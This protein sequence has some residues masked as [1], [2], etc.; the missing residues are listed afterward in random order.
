[1]TVKPAERAGVVH[2]AGIRC[3]CKGLFDLKAGKAK[4]FRCPF[5]EEQEQRLEDRLLRQQLG[6]PPKD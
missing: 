6:P 5:H 2:V 1:M 3:A 4:L